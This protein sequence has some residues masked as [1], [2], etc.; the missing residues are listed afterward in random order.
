[1]FFCVCFCVKGVYEVIQVSPEDTHK[2]LEIS[3][4]I[5]QCPANPGNYQQRPMIPYQVHPWYLVMILVW[6]EI[7]ILMR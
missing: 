6:I 4:K 7:K 1:M 3:D 2:Y 5:Q